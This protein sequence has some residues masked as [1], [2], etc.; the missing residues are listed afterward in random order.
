MRPLSEL[1]ITKLLTQYPQYLPLF[2][3]CNK[4]WVI[5]AKR[6][7]NAG[8]WCGACPKCAFAFALLAAFLPK[9]ELTNIFG[10]I[11]F[12][13]PELQTFYAELFGLQGSKPFECVGTVEETEAAF[14]MAH[15]RGDLEETAAM[16]MFTEKVLLGITNPDALIKTMMSPV[17]EHAIP[18]EFQSLIPQFR[19]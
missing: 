3:S 6:D 10:G 16:T 14:L 2:T 4:N 17:P 7:K 11:F 19:G 8:K 9:S 5:L 15:K 13:Y 18:E 12:A 1:H